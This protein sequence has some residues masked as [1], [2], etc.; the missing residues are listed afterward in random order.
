MR[1]L[2]PFF[3]VHVFSYVLRDLLP[4]LLTPASG[5][6][7]DFHRPKHSAFIVVV[8]EQVWYTVNL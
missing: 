2:V 7:A 6:L 8:G 1:G 5:W 4:G 3:I